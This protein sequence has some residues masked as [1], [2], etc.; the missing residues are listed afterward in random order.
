MPN[1]N[2]EESNM[3]SVVNPPAPTNE[4][5]WQHVHLPLD[6][7]SLV[8]PSPVGDP[9]E[10]W[11]NWCAM[12]SIADEVT[13]ALY[14]LVNRGTTNIPAALVKGFEAALYR[15]NAAFVAVDDAFTK[16]IN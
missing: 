8:D 11:K 15:L 14:Q 9:M 16:Y 7:G 10:P 3:S 5:V 2:Q 12:I 4:P 13:F 6:Q 1:Q